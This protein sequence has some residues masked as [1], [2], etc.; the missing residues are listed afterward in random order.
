M[1]AKIGR[2]LGLIIVSGFA[3]MVAITVTAGGWGRNSSNDDKA[4]TDLPKMPVSVIEVRRALIE[5]TDSYSGMIKPLERFKL[6]FDIAGRILE[7]GTNPTDDPRPDKS[8]AGQP[9]DEGDRVKAGQLLA[10]LDDRVLNSRLA[11][12]EAQLEEARARIREANARLEQ[13]QVDMR[14]A[15]ELK[16]HAVG[17]ITEADYLQYVTE[18]AVAEAQVSVAKA[19]VA[20]A[21][22]RV[23]TTRENLKDTRLVSPVGGVIAKRPANVG[24][25]VNPHQTIMEIIQ[26]DE[27]L[28]VVGVPEAYVGHIEPGQ[29]AHVQLLACDRFGRERPKIDGEV[30]RVAE[31][32][33]ETSGLF[34]V[35]IRLNNRDGCWKPGLIALARIVV[36]QIEGYRIPIE[37]A[38]FRE[39][40]AFLFTVDED[41]T[42]HRLPLK[43][44][45]EEGSDLV[46]RELPPGQRKIVN[47]GQHRLVDGREVKLVELG[48]A[49]AEAGFSTPVRAEVRSGGGRP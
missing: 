18:L 14:R 40:A 33:D 16:S 8:R 35:E 32:A 5:I 27:V 20:N 37:C 28:L 49:E 1:N 22:A 2:F 34:D 38:V 24:E 21:L 47:R 43:D 23:Q 44:W 26:V 39:K 17:A 29:R 41:L 6:G 36:D 42:A 46:I 13:A 10:R 48:V 15:K 30:Y 31:A 45:I 3:L 7:F 25:S 4:N 9:L 11:E 19:Q 12:D